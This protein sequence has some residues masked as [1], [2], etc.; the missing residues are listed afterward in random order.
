MLIV[1]TWPFIYISFIVH[2]VHDALHQRNQHNAS[3][4]VKR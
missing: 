2:I 1:E 4:T 3:I